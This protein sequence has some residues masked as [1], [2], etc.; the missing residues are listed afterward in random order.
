MSNRQAIRTDLIAPCGMN[1]AL[2]GAYQRSKDKCHGCRSAD[3]DK[4]KSCLKC[5]IV[6]CELRKEMGLKYCSEKCGEYPCKRL[7]NLDKRYSSSY[8][9]SLLENLEEISKLGIRAFVKDERTKW[10][11][12]SCGSAMCI[13][14][15]KCLDCGRP[16]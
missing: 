10:T 15:H 16:I 14:R 11:C 4:M 6:V 3:E 8:H 12:T 5:S 9:V 1:C 7:K 2:C 13:H